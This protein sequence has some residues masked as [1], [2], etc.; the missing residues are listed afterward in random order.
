[1]VERERGGGDKGGWGVLGGKVARGDREGRVPEALRMVRLEG[2]ERRKPGQLSGGQRQRVVLA[3]ALVNRPRVLLL[4]EPLGA[5]DLKL[6]QELQIELK[7]IQHEV[8][9]TFIY[10]T[11]DQDEALS[12]SDRIAVMDGGHILQIGTP[13]EVYAQPD[14][15][16]VAGFVGVSNLLELKVIKVNSNKVTVQLD[17][18]SQ[19][20]L[21]HST[22]NV[23]AGD[24]VFATIRPERIDVASEETLGKST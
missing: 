22:N 20:T 7:R 1:G 2:Y 18:S 17:K 11:H 19:V 4:D 14:S 3:R 23:K 13:R 15:K 8:G 21:T 6:R 9:I 10:V 5:L 12:M 24:K 16:F